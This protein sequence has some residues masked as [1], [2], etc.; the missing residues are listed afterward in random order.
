MPRNRLTLLAVAA[1]L[2]AGTARADG[3]PAGLS[4][5]IDELIGARLAKEGVPPA[6]RADDAEFFR[7]L[8]LDLNGRIPSL[9]Q[10]RDFLDDDRPAKRTLWIE[11]L[12][13]GP[14][15]AALYVRHFAHSWRRQLL[16]HTPTQPPAV[17]APLEGW[18]RKQG[19]ANTPYDRLVR[20]LLTD[21]EA[22]AFFQANQNKPEEMAGRTSRLLLGVR[23]ECAQ[24]HDDRAGGRWKR[25]QFWEYAAFFV[26]PGEGK[27]KADAY[28][29]LGP[30][31]QK[32]GPARIRVGESDVWVETRFPD[33]T[34]PD[35]KRQATPRAALAGWITRADNPYFARAAVN[36]LWRDFFGAPNC[37]TNWPGSS[38]PTTST[39]N[40]W[41]GPSPAARPT[42]APA[43]RRI[44]AR[45][46]HGC[47]PA[48]R[49]AA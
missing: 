45:P 42:S 6:P 1:L 39:A 35:W 48:P 25:A 18:L 23:L 26:G 24:C 43:G 41:S 7:R 17:V 11:E 33:G 47:S 34:R 15:N 14:D 12:L 22:G 8:S 16:E 38:R 21:P 49:C 28:L 32:P 44:P 13:D 36:R 9:D 31:Q 27:P 20:G 40:T 30:V 3:D 29:A 46:T 19:R 37:S 10:L 4:A 2:F 5:R